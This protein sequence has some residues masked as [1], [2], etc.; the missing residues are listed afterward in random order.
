[1][2]ANQSWNK[3]YLCCM[4]S[5]VAQW[6]RHVTTNQGIA[7]SSPA[8]INTFNGFETRPS[9]NGYLFQ[10]WITSFILR[11]SNLYNIVN[12]L[13]KIFGGHPGSHCFGPLVNLR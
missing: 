3:Q 9:Y 6:I 2:D 10:K 5:S 12:R 4:M 11:G 8:R 7:A 13:S 1:M